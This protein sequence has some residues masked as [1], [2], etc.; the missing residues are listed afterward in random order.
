MPEGPVFYN[1]DSKLGSD[2]RNLSNFVKLGDGLIKV[3]QDAGRGRLLAISL[4]EE[5]LVS[6]GVD[7][8][9]YLARIGGI[10]LSVSACSDR[11]FNPA[12][13]IGS[14]YALDVITVSK[15]EDATDEN[16]VPSKPVVNGVEMD[17]TK[18]DNLYY[19]KTYQVSTSPTPRGLIS[20]GG[21]PMSFG[22]KNE[23]IL[24][25]S[26]YD[27]TDVDRYEELKFFG[28]PIRVGMVDA[29]NKYYLI[30]DITNV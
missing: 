7:I 28:V 14:F 10:P 29:E 25:D 30:V 9:F 4:V 27:E 19:L 3:Y 1:N 21:V 16:T 11:D 6:R 12:S 26:G 20:F 5:S 15:S 17:I 23:L 22:D 24:R 2:D 8:S 13:G 18:V